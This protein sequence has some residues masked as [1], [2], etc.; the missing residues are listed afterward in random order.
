MLNYRRKRTF[1]MRALRLSLL[2][3]AKQKGRHYM[4]C[5][6]PRKQAFAGTV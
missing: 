1:D 3:N 4:F 2:L 5:F 6:A